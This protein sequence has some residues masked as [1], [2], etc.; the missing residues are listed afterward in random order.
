MRLEAL[1]RAGFRTPEQ[2][3]KARKI[4]QLFRSI[5]KDGSGFVEIDELRGGMAQF[6]LD[7]DDPLFEQV[8]ANADEDGDGEVTLDEFM[9]GT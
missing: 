2:M 4:K 6:G 7:P 1:A 5:D 3:E 9:T 8:M